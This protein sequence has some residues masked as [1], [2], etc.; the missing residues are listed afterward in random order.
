MDE[1]R[2]AIFS[3]TY[4][5]I[6]WAN[7]NE[8]IVKIKLIN[9]APRRRRGLFAPLVYDTVFSVLDLFATAISLIPKPIIPSITNSADIRLTVRPVLNVLE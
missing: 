2:T 6:F 3:E 8:F 1:F 9:K 5:K 4:D 7:M